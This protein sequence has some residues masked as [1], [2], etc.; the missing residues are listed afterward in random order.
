ME[1]GSSYDS[2]FLLDCCFSGFDGTVEDGAGTF[3]DWT[4]VETLSSGDAE[5]TTNSYDDNSYSRRFVDTAA[6]HFFYGATVAELHQLLHNP[7]LLKNHGGY[8]QHNPPLR[9]SEADGQP[10]MESILLAPL[11]GSKAAN[12]AERTHRRRGMQSYP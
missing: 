7:A 4:L 9:Y 1:C 8:S 3:T 10:I 5:S 6:A 11:K 12:L 2:L